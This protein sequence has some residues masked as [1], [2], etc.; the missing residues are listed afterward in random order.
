MNH[1]YIKNYYDDILEFFFFSFYTFLLLFY[2]F[3]YIL[4]YLIKQDKN[5]R[6]YEHFCRKIRLRNLDTN[7][8]H[9]YKAYY[10]FDKSFHR[11]IKGE[12]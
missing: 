1:K 10:F 11:S 2:C 4:G 9:E 8:Y 5:Y 12:H 3:S 6:S 7:M